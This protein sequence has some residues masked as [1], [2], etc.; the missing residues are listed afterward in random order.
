MQIPDEG[1]TV[2]LDEIGAC[3]VK[4]VRVTIERPDGGSFRVTGSMLRQWIN[5][6][7]AWAVDIDGWPIDRDHPWNH[8]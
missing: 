7:V 3:T 2:H 8:G 5:G 1:E 4:D 6:E